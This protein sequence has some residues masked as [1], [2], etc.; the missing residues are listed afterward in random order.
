MHQ[1]LHFCSLRGE[2]GA[3]KN[4][5]REGRRAASHGTQVEMGKSSRNLGI[6]LPT[7]TKGTAKLSTLTMGHGPMVLYG[8]TWDSDERLK[9]CADWDLSSLLALFATP[10]HRTEIVAPFFEIHAE[11]ILQAAPQRFSAQDA[12]LKL[13]FIV[14]HSHRMKRKTCGHFHTCAN[15]LQET[16]LNNWHPKVDAWLTLFSSAMPLLLFISHLEMLR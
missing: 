10:G 13:R 1:V 4:L 12:S 6:T 16:T 2:R 5:Q 8:L 3:L 14:W 11:N 15:I 9:A 7:H